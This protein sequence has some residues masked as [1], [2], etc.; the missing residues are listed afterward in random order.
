MTADLIDA[1][2]DADHLRSLVGEGLQADAVRADSV[3]AKPGTLVVLGLADGRGRPVGWARVLWP[4]AADK[5]AKVTDRAGRRG[6]VLV[7]RDLPGGLLLQAGHIDTDPGLGTP[8]RRARPRRVRDLATRPDAVLRHNP[9]R[10]VLVRDGDAVVR[11]RAVPDTLGRPLLSRLAELGLPVPRLGDDGSQEHVD[12][13]AF[14]G[15]T[16]LSRAPSPAG[17]RWAGGVLARLHAATDEVLADPR[18]AVPLGR[19]RRVRR[20]PEDALHALAPGLGARFDALAGRLLGR[21]LLPG[22]AVLVHGDASA[23]QV[24]VD[25]ASGRRQF[26]DFDRVGVGPAALDLG[27]WLAVDRLAGVDLAQP[28]LDGYAAAGGAVPGAEHLTTAL[29]HGLLSRV[30]APLRAG[31]PGWRDLVGDRLDDLAEVLQ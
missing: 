17:A 30:T 13:R 3:R 10:R 6:L 22:A 16:D 14:F 5:A 27:S 28:L 4:A 31:D 20:A 25:T 1:L 9:L 7:E 23:D 24:L 26:N 21:P 15:D 2:L 11:V 19:R 8:L 18:L 12:V 29:G